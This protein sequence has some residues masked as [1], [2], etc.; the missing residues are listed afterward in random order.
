[1]GRDFGADAPD[2]LWLADL[3][4][5]RTRSGWV[6]MAFVIDAYSRRVLG[7]QASRSLRT[8]LALDALDMAIAAR[9]RGGHSTDG[10]THHS[11]RGSQYVSVRYTERLHDNDIA[12]SVGS[13]GD[14]Y[15]NAMIESFNGL[16]K[17]E[18]IYPRGP[19]QGQSDVEFAT[20]EYVDW[21]NHRRSHSQL[22]PGRYTYTTPADCETAYYQNTTAATAV[23]QQKQSLPNPA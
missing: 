15:D 13:K 16:F 17:W 6:Y 9:R 8:D 11:D 2:R 4:W 14:S 7:W 5:V 18:L 20:L 23:A 22:L 19:W 10:V 3:T 21:Y 12:A 1:M